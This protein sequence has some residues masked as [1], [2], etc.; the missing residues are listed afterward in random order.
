MGESGLDP[1]V[2]PA[3]RER[4][5]DVLKDADL[6]VVSAKKIRASLA[7]L[8]E[9]SLP[10][11]VDL[12]A[13][14]KA[15][16]AEIRVCYDEV[17]KGGK[18]S[19]QKDKITLPGAGGVPGDTSKERTSKRKS[20]ET[21][22]KGSKK[23]TKDGDDEE[24]KKKRASNPN[25]A[26]NRPMRLSSEMAEVCGGNEVRTFWLIVRCHVTV[27]SS[28]YGRTLRRRI[29]KTN[30]TNVKFFAMRS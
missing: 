16:D 18:S 22:K 21:T 23:R 5:F 3:L 26:L 1:S 27:W 4:I 24:P 19:A 7:E 6:S 13:Q 20:T 29:C 28:N 11:G 12:S 10:A 25:S 15:I 8:P 30:R 17:T 2:A 14:K 9:G